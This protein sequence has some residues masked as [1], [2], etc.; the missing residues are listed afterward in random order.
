METLQRKVIFILLNTL[1]L[2]MN[3]SLQKT[4]IS[5]DFSSVNLD[6][7]VD[8]KTRSERKKPSVGA[9][10]TCGKTPATVT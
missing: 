4:P 10:V 7:Q 9:L 3:L 1:K 2:L 6:P 8:L 5:P